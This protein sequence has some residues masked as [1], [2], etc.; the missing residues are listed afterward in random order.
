[1]ADNNDI[2]NDLSIDEILKDVRKMNGDDVEEEKTWSLS[3]IDALLADDDAVEATQTAETAQEAKTVFEPSSFAVSSDEVLTPKA[4]KKS[5]DILSFID[6]DD[7]DFVGE[8]EKFR[9][10]KSDKQVVNKADKEEKVEVLQKKNGFI[11]VLGVD[12]GFIGWIKEENFG[13]N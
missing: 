9:T 6:D 4:E 5:D 3:E 12:N 10:V 2:L 11:K 13:T 8:A 1:M 7:D